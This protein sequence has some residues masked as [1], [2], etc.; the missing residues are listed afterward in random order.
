MPKSKAQK[1]ANRKK[2][3]ALRL[4][5]SAPLTTG[6]HAVA[7]RGR[8]KVDRDVGPTAQTLAKLK[9][10]TLAMLRMLKVKD[11]PFLSAEL[12]EAGNEILTAWEQITIV[13]DRR[14][15]IG[16]GSASLESERLQKIWRRWCGLPQRPWAEF[17]TIS[18]FTTGH[19]ELF[20]RCSVGPDVIAG[21]LLPNTSDDPKRREFDI[22]AKDTLKRALEWWR[23]AARDV[24]RSGGVS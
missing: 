14:T 20:K 7:T 2:R 11:E 6:K 17:K 19:G 15:Y 23:Q 24:G 22:G 8:P 10:D 18:D 4:A 9:P 13:V 12:V 16:G 5:M 3:N 1:R 21:W